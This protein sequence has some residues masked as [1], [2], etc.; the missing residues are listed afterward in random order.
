MQRAWQ[1]RRAEWRAPAQHEIGHGGRREDVGSH[2]HLPPFGLLGRHERR[3]ADDGADRRQ[4]GRLQPRETE[5]E[6]LQHAVVLHETVARLEV[7]MH[8]AMLVRGLQALVELNNQIDE[9]LDIERG[10]ASAGTRRAEDP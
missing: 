3:R 7:A 10:I 9:R 4:R 6:N 1:I 2:V 5:V 8:R